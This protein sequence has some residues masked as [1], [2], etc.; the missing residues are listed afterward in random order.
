MAESIVMKIL[1]TVR[2][3]SG[4]PHPHLLGVCYSDHFFLRGSPI[5][6]QRNSFPCDTYY[7]GL[8]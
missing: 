3:F 5:R 4:V 6:R 2:F 1:V 7:E 8:F